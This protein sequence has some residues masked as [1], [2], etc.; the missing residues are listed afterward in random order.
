MK[1]KSPSLEEFKNYLV[2]SVAKS[3]AITNRQSYQEA[4]ND[5]SNIKNMSTT[6]D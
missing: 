3:I 1:V 4:L 5:F 6:T 2:N